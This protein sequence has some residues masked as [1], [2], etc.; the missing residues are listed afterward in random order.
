MGIKRETKW[1]LGLYPTSEGVELMQGEM[2]M[3]SVGLLLQLCLWPVEA[4]L[5]G[6]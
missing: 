3:F 4:P 5:L 6:A 2:M 1:G